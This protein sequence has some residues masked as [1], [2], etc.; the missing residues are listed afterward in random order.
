LMHCSMRRNRPREDAA[1]RAAFI[2]TD[3]AVVRVSG[4]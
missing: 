3:A 1:R 4:R 2:E